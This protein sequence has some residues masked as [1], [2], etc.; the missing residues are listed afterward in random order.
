[1]VHPE[2]PGAVRSTTGSDAVLAAMTPSPSA[3]LQ[4]G[5]V[6]RAVKIAV[7][8]RA[9]AQWESLIW[10]AATRA[11][12]NRRLTKSNVSTEDQCSR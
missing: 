12:E 9:A 4:C 11:Y 7:D 6:G 1:M 2:V 3:Q 5:S 10:P 8:G